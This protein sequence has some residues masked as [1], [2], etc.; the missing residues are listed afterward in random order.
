M[1]IS[2]REWLAVAFAS[3]ASPVR[4]LAAQSND[5]APLER[6][7]AK[8]IEEFG[9]QGIHR[10]GTEVDR[11]SAGWLSAQITQTGLAPSLELFSLSRVDPIEATLTVGTR[12]IEG[13]PFFD[14]AF[15]DGAGV[16]GRLG[17][18]DSDAEVGVTEAAPN[19]AAAGPLGNARRANRHK[20]I[21]CITRG[22]RAGL[23]PSNADLFLQPF[24]P[25]VLQVSSEEAAWLGEQ[26]KA[27]MPVRVVAQVRRTPATAFNVTTKIAG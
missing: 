14:G 20:A 4:A 12:R 1:S 3:L 15:T 27:G 16:S 26:A 22:Q 2:R 6:R 7:I 23:C 5:H 8:L 10:T 13:V 25:P 19:T 17:A 21:V 11:R 24:G 18:I 9:E